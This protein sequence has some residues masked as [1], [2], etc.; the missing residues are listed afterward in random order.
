MARLNRVITIEHNV[1]TRD[2]FGSVISGWVLLA[3][4]WAE[5]LSVKPAERFIKTSART[6]NKSTS[7]LR[8]LQ[9]EDVD[10]TMRVIDDN[11]VT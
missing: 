2:R 7:Q 8:M 1:E 6:V 10:E 3:E 11:G 4:V 5:R 9:R